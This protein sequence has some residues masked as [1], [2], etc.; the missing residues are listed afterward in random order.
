MTVGHVDHGHLAWP[1]PAQL[2]DRANPEDHA[3]SGLLTHA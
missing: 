1:R 2:L 3:R